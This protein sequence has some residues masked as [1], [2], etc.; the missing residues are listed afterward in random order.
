[1]TYIPGSLWSL[2]FRPATLLEERVEPDEHVG[3]ILCERELAL[4]P[5]FPREHVV[6]RQPL[7]CLQISREIRVVLVEVRIVFETP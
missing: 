4:G 2:E 3:Q 6:A 5:H 7:V 1:M